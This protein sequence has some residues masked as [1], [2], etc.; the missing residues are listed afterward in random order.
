MTKI[1]A[2]IRPRSFEHG[3]DLI[4]S[5]Q[6]AGA[7]VIE[8]WCDRLDLETAKKLV[9]VSEL[10]VIVNLKD[11]NEK[12]EFKGNIYDRIKY[13]EEL[14]LNGAAYLDLPYC[15]EL[16]SIDL[17]RL[18]PNLIVS[19][20]DFKST[21]S[22]DEIEV[23]IN[24]ILSLKPKIIK[25]AFQINQDIDLNNLLKLQINRRD[26]WG[27][28]IILGMGHKGMLTRVMSKTFQHPFTFAS[29]DKYSKTA[30]GQ[31]TISQLK[32]LWKRFGFI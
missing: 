17:L 28:S 22:L 10:P 20:H 15:T 21:P 1:A 2:S 4:L 3:E 11:K 18:Q 14:V 5:A 25:L 8:L 12:G 9:V 31:M 7:Q 23:I 30:P 19:Y 27:N 6:I 32:K 29:I 24:N 13:L 26:L 16:P